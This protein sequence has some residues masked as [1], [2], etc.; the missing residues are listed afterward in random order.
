MKY[1]KTILEFINFG[2][3]AMASLITVLVLFIM[4]VIE[5][6]E[7][8]QEI[9]NDNFERVDSVTLVDIHGNIIIIEE[10]GKYTRF[11]RKDIE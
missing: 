4:A 10:N 5:D 2:T 9:K 8:L 7:H 11:F 1:L 3:I 6:G